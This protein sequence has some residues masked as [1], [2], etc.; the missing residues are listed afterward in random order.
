MRE[1]LSAMFGELRDMVG[2]LIRDA[3]E[4]CALK[5]DA[6]RLGNQ[7]LAVL[8]GCIVLAK[9]HTDAAIPRHGMELFG[10]HLD[11]LFEPT[12]PPDRA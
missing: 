10:E 11:L 8:E 12:R 2:G 4:S 7:F 9:A 1:R 3:A 6:A 5:L